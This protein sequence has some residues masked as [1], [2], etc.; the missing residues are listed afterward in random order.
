M[1][2]GRWMEIE[3]MQRIGIEV[4]N[5]INEK[6]G[7]VHCPD[8][9]FLHL[10]E[11]VG[12]VARELSKKQVGWRKDFDDEKLGDELIDVIYTALIIARDEGIDI[13]AAFLRKVEK[14][15]KRFELE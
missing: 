8:S 1:I 12:E 5:K 15:K 3:E 9:M 7:C 14:V 10:A 4:M 2:R 13:E 11:E 6:T